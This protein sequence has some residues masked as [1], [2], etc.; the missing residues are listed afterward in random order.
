MIA[1]LTGRLI[2]KS[3]SH[4]I[5]DVNGVGYEVQIAL[6]TYFSLPNVQEFATL[7]I[8]TQLRND[9][10]Q[11]FGFL[12]AQ[13]KE[14]FTLLTGITGIGPKLALSML[15]SLSVKDLVSAIQANDVDTLFSVPG[16][17]RKSASRIVLELKDKVGRLQGTETHAG[18]SPPTLSSAALQEDAASALLNLGYRAPEVKKAIQRSLHKNQ[19]GC[20]LEDLIRE[21][22][23][24]LIKS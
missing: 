6:S 8:S 24:E 13:E 2:V 21:S 22:L 9:T 19:E 1:G 3:P 4:V 23:K 5:L 15:S 7:D 16:I 17:G 10:I 11:L 12:T 18:E 14:T 20:T